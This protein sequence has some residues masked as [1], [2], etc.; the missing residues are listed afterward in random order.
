V[1]TPV[2][3]GAGA[4]PAAIMRFRAQPSTADAL[5]ATI[6]PLISAERPY[7]SSRP[8][9]APLERPIRLGVL[10]SGG[11]DAGNF[12]D[13]IAGRPASGGDSPGRCQPRRCGGVALAGRAGLR[14]EIV[15]TQGLWQRR[16]KFPAQFFAAVPRGPRRPR[17]ASRFSSPLSKSPTTFFYRVMNIPSGADSRLCGRG[18]Y[19]HKVHEAVLERARRSPVAPRTSPTTTTITADHFAAVR[20]CSR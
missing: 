13:K 18:F 12:L 3:R 16:P 14:C 17:H 11:G 4:R 5:P 2:R 15:E 19:G 7:A 10:I 20:R 1:S 9:S 6:F 8:I